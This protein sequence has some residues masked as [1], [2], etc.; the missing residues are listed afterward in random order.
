M[1]PKKIDEAEFVLVGI[2]EEFEEMNLLKDCPAYMKGIELWKKENAEWIIPAW[3]EYCVKKFSNQLSD[4]LEILRNM[5]KD[6][7]YFIVTTCI[8]SRFKEVAWKDQ[9]IVMPCGDNEQVQCIAGC[10]EILNTISNEQRRWMNDVFKRV[11]E[12]EK[13]SLSK[14]LSA[15]K[16]LGECDL[17]HELLVLNNIYSENYNENGYLNQWNK[18]LKWLQGTVNRKLLVLELGVGMKFPSVIRWPFEK[19]VFF[20]K[21][22][23][24][25]RINE[26]LYQMTEELAG[27]GIGIQ[28]NAIEW[29]T[30]L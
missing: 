10:K 16:S 3:R 19:T 26:F 20:N 7:N 11:Y 17:C 18:Y 8:D 4:A 22:A 28:K 14:E 29:L 12:G 25:V 15:N 24:L 27:K 13:V 23:E 9:K 6:K 1:I 5:I 30:D 21:K 2:G